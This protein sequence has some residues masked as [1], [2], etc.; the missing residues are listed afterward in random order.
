MIA[1]LPC[2]NSVPRLLD[3]ERH[4]TLSHLGTL[5]RGLEKIDEANP[6]NR[7]RVLQPVGD[8]RFH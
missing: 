7:L 6:K 4:V 8:N 3:D 2:L 1:C 5:K